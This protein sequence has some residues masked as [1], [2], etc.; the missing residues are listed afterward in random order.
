MSLITSKLQTNPNLSLLNL[1][2]AHFGY[3]QFRPLQE[4]I[5][6]HVLSGKDALVLMPTGGGKS[7]CYQLPA[8]IF[9]G[10]TIVISPLIALMKDQVDGLKT[11]GIQAEYINSSLP[12]PEILRIQDEAR[13]GKLNMI[14]V[15]PERLA[16]P[17]FREFL[18]SLNVSLMA[19]DEA[20]CVSEWGHD[21]RPD[22]LNLKDLREDFPSVPVIALT[23]T[24]TVKVRED[25]VRHLKLEN[26]KLFQSSFN[27]ENLIYHVWPKQNTFKTLTQFL[28]QYKNQS[29]IIYCFSRKDTELLSSQLCTNGFSALPYHAGLDVELRSLT[30]EKFIK[31]E[32]QIIVATIAFGMGI[33][34]PDIRLVVHYDL[35]K[36]VEGYYQ[37]TGRAGRDGLP[38]AC[39][40]FFSYGDK[41]KQEYFIEQIQDDA[42]RRKV[43]AKLDQ[44]ISFCQ[45]N[46]CRRKFLLEYFGETYLE[47]SCGRCDVCIRGNQTFDATDIAQTIL[48]S[49]IATGERFGMNYVVEVLRGR[50]NQK[51]LDRRHERLTIFGKLSNHNESEIKELIGCLLDKKFLLKT[52]EEYPVLVTT[53][54]GQAFLSSQEK[55]FFPKLRERVEWQKTKPKVKSAQDLDYNRGLFEKLRVLRL[56]I[57]SRRGVPPFVIFPDAS[58]YEM[59]YY[60]PQDRLSFSKIFG[61][62]TKKLEVFSEDFISVIGEY[63][64]VHELKAPVDSTKNPMVSAS[65][66]NLPA[67]NTSLTH[68]ETKRLL[69][70]RLSLEEIS[71]RRNL[72]VPTILNHLEKL[73]ENSPKAKEIC[74]DHLTLPEP[75]FSRIKS[76]F[77]KTGTARLSPVKEM[78]GEDFSYEEIRLA[79]VL[80]Q[81]NLG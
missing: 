60:L 50:L 46:R 34:K 80:I 64:R 1:L 48:Q 74:L 26:A 38:S 40:L 79:R 13:Q 75:R 28:Q 54:S 25:I 15:A 31:D 32:V 49:V 70:E 53:K 45:I 10:V 11:N 55:V 24:A 42:E 56:E 51:V 9:E 44:M 47:E 3:G 29:V 27:R 78:L 71:R 12:F 59:S 67:T 37:E 76:A 41:I 65:S 77:E 72:T 23:A 63:S 21:F 22:Y 2:K 68:E 39:V 43:R 73:V 17:G 18:R 81:H 7:L 5:I 57:A 33:D 14:Y 36:S 66:F 4:E 61:V 8:L 30:Q 35:P 16:L 62:G 6:R 52:G 20:H 58:L 69:N 19:V